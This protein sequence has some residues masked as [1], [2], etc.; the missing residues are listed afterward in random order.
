MADPES[1]IAQAQSTE[2][3]TVTA[4]APTNR[5]SGF[6]YARAGQYLSQGLDKLSS[7]LDAVAVP[8]AQQQAASDLQNQNL[9]TR[10]AQGN[11]TVGK[12]ST[13]PILGPAGEA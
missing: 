7:G 6:Q 13:L 1:A 5:V 10:D 8:L 4:Q 3:Q 9:V 11:I 12:P 2:Q